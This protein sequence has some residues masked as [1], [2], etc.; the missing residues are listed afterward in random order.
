M[1]LLLILA[2]EI[3][4]LFL[5]SQTNLVPQKEN[6]KTV[7][8]GGNYWR[9]LHVTVMRKAMSGRVRKNKFYSKKPPV[10]ARRLSGGF[11]MLF[12]SH[13]MLKLSIW[14]N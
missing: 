5:L 10:A 8:P 2:V 9:I 4:L 3:L 11:F 7:L 12:L 6:K 13:K 14:L 1:G